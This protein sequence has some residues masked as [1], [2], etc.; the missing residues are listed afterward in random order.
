MKNSTFQN[1]DG[2]TIIAPAC[3]LDRGGTPI[4]RVC[5]QH[6][7]QTHLRKSMTLNDNRRTPLNI[8]KNLSKSMDIAENQSNENQWESMALMKINGNR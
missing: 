6:I 1:I 7:S 3:C 2:V 5:P 8:D 4:T